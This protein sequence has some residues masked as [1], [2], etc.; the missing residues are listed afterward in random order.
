MPATTVACVH[1]EEISTYAALAPAESL[2]PTYVGFLFSNSSNPKGFQRLLYTQIHYE[3][4]E[5]QDGSIAKNN[6]EPKRST[7]KEQGKEA[8]R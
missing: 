7:T 5:R 8:I 1:L 6:H 3:A 2:D 4:Y